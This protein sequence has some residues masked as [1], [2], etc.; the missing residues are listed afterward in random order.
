MNKQ[1]SK[2]FA[3]LAPV[4]EML[5]DVKRKTVSVLKVRADL[6]I[7]S[8]TQLQ[9]GVEFKRGFSILELSISI[10]IIALLVAGITAGSS[11]KDKLELNNVV[12]DISAISLAVKEFQKTYN[13][14]PGDMFNAQDSFGSANTYNG[15][16]NNSLGAAEGTGTNANE[17][18]LFWQHLAL[19]GLISGSYDGATDGIGGRMKTPIKNGLYGAAKASGAT[20][21]L[22]I[23]V[24][25][26]SAYGLF[27][28]KQAYD[29][30]TKYD[31]GNPSTGNIRGVDGTGETAGNCNN[32]TPSPNVYNLSVS[33]TPCVMQFYLEQ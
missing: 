9:A 27:T 13:A 30:D 24:G 18:L 26:A 6:S 23:T 21:K 12:N 32:T 33:G 3:K 28:T 20:G 5:G 14:L 7:T 19:A 17:T 31:D 10:S 8:T 29:Y 1:Q 22:Y 25:K 15:N 2:T 16:G 11:L 4:M